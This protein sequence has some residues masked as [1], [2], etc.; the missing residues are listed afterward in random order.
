MK[1]LIKKLSGKLNTTVT[2]KLNCEKLVMNTLD[3]EIKTNLQYY[4]N[5]LNDLVLKLNMNFIKLISQKDLKVL[6]IL[7]KN[8]LQI[9][10]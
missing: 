7:I 8:T 2:M 10:I 9:K 5:K 3:G 1:N 4:E 6:I